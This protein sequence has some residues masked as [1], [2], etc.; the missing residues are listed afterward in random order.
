MQTNGIGLVITVRPARNMASMKRSF[1]HKY[2]EKTRILI[3]NKHIESGINAATRLPVIWAGRLSQIQ[4]NGGRE[5]LLK[6]H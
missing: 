2:E 1:L 3:K 4:L 6:P 5:V